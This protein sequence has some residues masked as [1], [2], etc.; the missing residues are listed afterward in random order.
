MVRMRGLEPPRCHH[1]R[2][3]RPARLPV[4]PHPR[5]DVDLT[6]ASV[7]CQAGFRLNLWTSAPA[8]AHFVSFETIEPSFSAFAKKLIAIKVSIA[9]IDN[10][11][12]AGNDDDS[13]IIPP[14][15]AIAE[16]EIVIS[17]SAP[18]TNSSWPAAVQAAI[19]RVV[20]VH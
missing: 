6:N 16:T 3:L 15:S 9:T 4:P 19:A 5:T 10:H 12:A 14:D 20:T 13:A 1:H 17:E 7:G 11:A 8:S 2:L 18:D